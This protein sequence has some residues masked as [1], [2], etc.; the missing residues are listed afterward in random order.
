MVAGRSPGGTAITVY[1]QCQTETMVTSLAPFSNIPVKIRSLTI[2]V[3]TVVYIRHDFIIF[4]F[5]AMNLDN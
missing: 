4:K 1:D 3:Y 5:V 2:I